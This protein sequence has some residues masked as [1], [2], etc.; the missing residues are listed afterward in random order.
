MNRLYHSQRAAAAGWPH[1]FRAKHSGAQDSNI[2][3]TRQQDRNKTAARQRH[4]SKKAAKSQQQDSNNK[5]APGAEPDCNK[6]RSKTQQKKQ[7]GKNRPQQYR[8]QA[9]TQALQNFNKK[10]ESKAA[11]GA[12]A[13]LGGCAAAYGNVRGRLSIRRP[14]PAAVQGLTHGVRWEP[15]GPSHDFTPWRV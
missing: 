8:N 10:K 13:Q 15:V 5:K 1:S 14:P 9:A 3:A 2:A 12:F 7:H 4:D 6:N 11:T